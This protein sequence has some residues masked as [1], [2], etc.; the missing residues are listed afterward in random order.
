M[1]QLK[2][3]APPHCYPAGMKSPTVIDVRPLLRAGR[4]PYPLLR[5]RL[6]ALAA[7][8]TLTVIAPFLPSPLIELA[9]SQGMEVRPSHRADGAWSTEISRRP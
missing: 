1:T 5:A 8:E 7:G 3:R 2:A 6:A 4:E 9:R